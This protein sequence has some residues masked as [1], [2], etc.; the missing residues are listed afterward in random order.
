MTY[1]KVTPEDRIPIKDR[2]YKRVGLARVKQF[3]LDR[4]E[5]KC[6]SIEYIN[7]KTS[8]LFECK[9]GHQWTAIWTNIYKGKW[10][11][12]CSKFA[13]ERITRIF[14]ESI[15]DKK[16]LK[17]R[18]EWLISPKGYKLELDGF[19]EEL[20]LAFE[21][22]GMQH[23]KITGFSR[24]KTILNKIKLYD[25]LKA[26]LCEDNNIKLIIIPQV[27]DLTEIKDLKQFIYDQ[28]NKANVNI[29]K[30]IED[31]IIDL[32]MG[33][34]SFQYLEIYK[35]IAKNKGGECVSENYINSGSKLIFVCSKGHQWT[36]IPHNILK[37]CWCPDC[38]NDIRR[39]NGHSGFIAAN[40]A[41]TLKRALK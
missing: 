18:P 27:P 35:N 8:L 39:L 10:C 38:A 22:Q 21:H 28:C 13:G 20:G 24:T 7:S 30:N 4:H 29:S 14:F 25:I 40:K 19:C 33:P 11:P 37:G 1:I 5:G 15:F 32:N 31:V 16:F 2:K 17:A 36:A 9:D 23:Y 3:V 12:I 26:K 41:L 6:L 34:L